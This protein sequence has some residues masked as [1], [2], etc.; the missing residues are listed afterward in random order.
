[1]HKGLELSGQIINF[2]SAL[3]F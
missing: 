3:F 1:M 2:V